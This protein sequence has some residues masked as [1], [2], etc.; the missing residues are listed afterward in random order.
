[1]KNKNKLRI[2]KSL[3]ITCGALGIVLMSLVSIKIALGVLLFVLSD[4]L[5]DYYI[6]L[7]RYCDY[8]R[9]NEN[10]GKK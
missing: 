4:S 10:D 2:I 5:S 7:K 9:C 1:M 8:E 3:A 6:I